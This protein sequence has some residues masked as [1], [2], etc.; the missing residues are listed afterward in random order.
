MKKMLLTL[1][2]DLVIKIQKETKSKTK[3]KA[4]L[5]LMEDYIKR[6]KLKRLTD[7]FGKGFGLSPSAFAKI[8]ASS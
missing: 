4:I 3:S 8:R 6:S 1:P 5:L 7:R 2:Q